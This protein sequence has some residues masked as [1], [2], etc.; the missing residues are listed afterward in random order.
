MWLAARPLLESILTTKSIVLKR[1]SD[2]M[3]RIDG[4]EVAKERIIQIAKQAVAATY[5]APQLTS[6]LEVKSEIVIGED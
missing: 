4:K 2:K 3:Y 1:K 6:K 5:K